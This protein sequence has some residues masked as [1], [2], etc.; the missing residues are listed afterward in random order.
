M[1]KTR[2][3]VEIRELCFEKTY[4]RFIL[5]DKTRIWLEIREI[6][7]AREIREIE[8]GGGVCIY[9]RCNINYLKRPDLVPN[10]LEAV[11]L[12][13]KQSN[14]HLSFQQFTDH[15]IPKLKTL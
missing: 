12:E 4:L 5:L 1:D 7:I 3:W 10:D 9:A 13:I 6:L 11:S 14:S 2:I 8:R 15:Q